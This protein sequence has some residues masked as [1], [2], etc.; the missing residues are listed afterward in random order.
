MVVSSG[1]RLPTRRSDDPVVRQTSGGGLRLQHRGDCDAHSS[2]GEP[3]RQQPAAA[4]FV[5]RRAGH[6]ITPDVDSHCSTGS[7]DANRIRRAD[8]VLVPHV[9]D[10]DSASGVA[11]LCRRRG[12]QALRHCSEGM[13]TVRHHGSTDCRSNHEGGW[14]DLPVGHHRVFVVQTFHGRIRQTTELSSGTREGAHL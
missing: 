10:P 6:I 1:A 8:G 2:H 11:D 7:L 14:I 3:K 12:V 5:A 13:G 4:L 9:G